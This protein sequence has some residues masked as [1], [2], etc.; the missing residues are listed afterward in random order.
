MNSGLGL[1]LHTSRVKSFMDAI[2]IYSRPICVCFLISYLALSYLTRWIASSQTWLR[3][4]VFLSWRD[5]SSKPDLSFSVFY[6]SS[7]SRKPI[8]AG[9]YPPHFPTASFSHVNHLGFSN[10]W[11]APLERPM[12]LTPYPSLSHSADGGS[13]GRSSLRRMQ[14]H[15]LGRFFDLGIALRG[16]WCSWWR[17]CI[18]LLTWHFRGS[19]LWV[20]LLVMMIRVNVRLFLSGEFL[21]FLCEF[22][23]G[24]LGRTCGSTKIVTSRLCS[25]RPLKT[26]H[27]GFRV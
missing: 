2:Q 18:I 13:M 1:W 12:F 9:I 22:F 20:S 14:L 21:P 16:R 24:L 4:F 10:T 25:P 17:R 7:S 8:Q 6:V 5:E 19:A 27:L 26:N 3:M 11:K 15:M 23:C